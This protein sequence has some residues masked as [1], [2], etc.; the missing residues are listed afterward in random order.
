M[1]A[2]SADPGFEHKET[3]A[4]MAQAAQAGGFTA[5]AVLPNTQPSISNKTTVE[6]ILQGSKNLPVHIWPMGSISQKAE[7]KTLAEMYDMQLAGAVAFTDGLAP[8]QNPV[9]LLKAL[10]YTQ[11]FN[12]VVVQMPVL[13]QFA[14]MGLINEGIVSTQLGLPG[15]PAIGEYLAVVQ[16][17]E[18]AKYT[19]GNLHI[20]GV[21]TIEAV[22]AIY[23]AKTRGVNLSCSVSSLHLLFS[24]E[25]VKTYDTNL[26]LLTPLR[27]QQNKEQLLQAVVDGK[28]DAIASMHVPQDWDAKTCEFEHAEKGAIH[29]QTSFAALVKALPT[30]TAEKV[31]ELLHSHPAHILQKSVASFATNAPLEATIYSLSGHY[32]YTESNNKSK[33][34][35]SPLIN[36]TFHGKVLATVNKGNLYLNI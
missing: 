34:S 2:F 29:L 28:V 8:I 23:Q 5:V 18:L 32:E 35:N 22:N 9:L 27:T 15:I 17:I 14:Q 1:F 36:Q 13:Q 4:S 26:K 33:C 7:G 3:L 6:Y 12:G 30:I 19:G 11:A 16:L 21:S 31:A 25:D 24:D 20:A 10:Q